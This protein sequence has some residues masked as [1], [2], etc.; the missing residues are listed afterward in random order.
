[1]AALT[2]LMKINLPTKNAGKGF[3]FCINKLLLCIMCFLLVL[4]RDMNTHCSI[5]GKEFVT[6]AAGKFKFHS[7]SNKM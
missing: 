5:C 4:T 1:M 7:Q 3:A 6:E 2:W